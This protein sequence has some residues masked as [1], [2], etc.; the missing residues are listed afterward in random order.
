[1]IASNSDAIRANTAMIHRFIEAICLIK[2]KISAF[3]GTSFD[4]C[5]FLDEFCT[6]H[7]I[8]QKGQRFVN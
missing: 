8:P 2:L 6:C 5:S 7:V 4:S 3:I 1:M